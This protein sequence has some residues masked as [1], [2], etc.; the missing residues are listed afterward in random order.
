M[1]VMRQ[2]AV[3]TMTSC[4]FVLAAALTATQALASPNGL[5][6]ITT[7]SVKNAS[8]SMGAYVAFKR[9]TQPTLVITESKTY[10]ANGQTQNSGWSNGAT[11]PQPTQ[12]S[13]TQVRAEA[14][15]TWLVANYAARG[16]KDVM[17]VG[18]PCPLQGDLPMK[19]FFPLKTAEW[20]Y[21]NNQG[22]RDAFCL[23]PKPTPTNN[24]QCTQWKDPHDPD[25]SLYNDYY[26]SNLTYN[27]PL[28]A[29]GDIKTIRLTDFTHQ[30]V[31]VGRI[32]VTGGNVAALDKILVKS[33][34]YATSK[35]IA[36]RKGALLSMN[37][38][39][40]SN[41]PIKDRIE[42]SY[43]PYGEV[44]RDTLLT[45]QGFSTFRIHWGF[46]A[47]DCNAN[48]SGDATKLNICL[49]DA[50]SGDLNDVS[51]TNMGSVWAGSAWSGCSGAICSQPRKRFG[52][53]HWTGHGGAT[54]A[55]DII[56]VA[57]SNDYSPYLDDTHP[58]FVVSQSCSS[59][60]PR[61]PNNI[62]AVLLRNGAIGFLGGAVGTWPAM[63]SWQP[64]PDLYSTKAGNTDVTYGFI[65]ELVVSG[66]PA[67]QALSAL[68]SH[69]A[70][71]IAGVVGDD[72]LQRDY[73]AQL[74]LFTLY[75][76]PT[77]GMANTT[78][79][80]VV[81]LPPTTPVNVSLTPGQTK[82]LYADDWPSK[83]N[84]NWTA[85]IV[86]SVNSLTGKPI[87]NGTIW[88]NGVSYSIG[89]NGQYYQELNIAD[90]GP[91]TI[92]VSASVVTTLQLVLGNR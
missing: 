28:D 25:R 5:A 82:V 32:P 39:A 59:S 29:S 75:G 79:P 51:V 22:Y 63:N 1:S 17:L 24:Q 12:L 65:K 9:Q 89:G 77:L 45:P 40:Y 74:L 80:G 62:G 66:L 35:D 69:L 26:Y 6:I 23:A 76:D 36:W 81:T 71:V 72:Y 68:R 90:Q 34:N 50:G 33:M 48:F 70:G 16:I 41:M 31:N 87:P 88:V 46:T 37:T 67:G 43:V 61:E 11:L 3:T 54:S 8:Q 53:V 52:L 55:G 21:P 13:T 10:L 20:D 73:A 42:S 49:G 4:V 14:L 15:R 7:E 78:N 27:W 19:A 60:D 92:E 44:V 85:N 64:L 91:Y 84:P 86:L 83:G 47:A 30:D 38:H 2:S 57:A 18:N 58:A 56:D